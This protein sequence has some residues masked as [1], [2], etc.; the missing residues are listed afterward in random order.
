[1]HICLSQVANSERNGFILQHCLK[2]KK[3]NWKLE[4]SCYV[5]AFRR[6]PRLR[7]VFYQEEFESSVWIGTWYGVLYVQSSILVTLMW[8]CHDWYKAHCLSC[9]A[10]ATHAAWRVT[11]RLTCPAD[12]LALNNSR[13]YFSL[14]YPIA[15]YQSGTGG[16]YMTRS[17]PRLR[18]RGIRLASHLVRAPNS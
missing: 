16:S 2:R 8:S 12:S 5:V 13:R 17:L 10:C 15:Q 4:E 7:L 18:L 3:W 9:S 11:G 6:L 14:R 1:M